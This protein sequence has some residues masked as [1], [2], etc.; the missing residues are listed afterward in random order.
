MGKT[1]LQPHPF[2]VEAC[3][4]LSGAIYTDWTAPLQ[5]GPVSRLRRDPLKGR[6]PRTQPRDIE[7]KAA[8]AQMKNAPATK[9]KLSLSTSRNN[10]QE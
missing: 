10:S 9:R 8:P 1:G 5:R 4:R 7:I 3:R 2:R 6:P